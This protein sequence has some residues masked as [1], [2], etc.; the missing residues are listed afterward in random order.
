[1]R[2]QMG[3]ELMRN[4]RLHK[5]PIVGD[6]LYDDMVD[7]VNHVDRVTHPDQWMIMPLVGLAFATYFQTP[8][9]YLSWNEPHTCLPLTTT[10]PEARP[11]SVTLAV[12][13]VGL[14]NHFVPV[15]QIS[16]ISFVLS[17]S[18]IFVLTLYFVLPL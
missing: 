13:L 18:Y 8:L 1:M 2:R 7:L 14:A 12:A 17:N 3:L 11:T 6:E 5:L 9:V 15:R 10:T 4:R 16:H